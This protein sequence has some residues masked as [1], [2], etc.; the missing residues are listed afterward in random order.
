LGIVSFIWA[1]LP[2]IW[3]KTVEHTVLV[4]IAVG[5]A[6]IIGVPVGIV[7]TQHKKIANAVLYAASVL[8][9]IPSIAL[10][11]IMIPLLS[12]FGYGVGAVPAMIAVLLYSLLPIIRNTY[13]A[14]NNI[15]PALREAAR[16]LGMRR[17]E[18]LRMVEIPIAL[19]VI[20]A[21]VRVAVVMNIGVMTIAT[22]IGAGGL[23][24]LINAGIAQTD[25]NQLIAGALAVSILAVT[26][27]YALLLLQ[28]VLTP[29]GTQG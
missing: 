25:S 9:T 27:D 29:V 10:F 8:I 19:P 23:G 12:P 22:Y 2:V 4:S 15:D 14:I 28:K 16:G 6:I 5:L 3:E 26:F 17:T 20:L 1:S 24:D 13:S 7:I 18:R 11:G 21:G